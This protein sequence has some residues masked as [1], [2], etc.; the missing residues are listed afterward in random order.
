MQ[1]RNKCPM[2][3]IFFLI[4][5]GCI[6]LSACLSQRATI[7]ATES[8]STPM[9]TPDI[10]VQSPSTETII[11]PGQTSMVTPII[12]VRFTGTPTMTVQPISEYYRQNGHLYCIWEDTPQQA[13]STTQDAAT[14]ETWYIYSNAT[15]GFS[16]R[17]PSNWTLSECTF[18]HPHFLRLQPAQITDEHIMLNIWFRRNTENIGITRTGIGSG[19]VV[20]QGTVQ[21]LN[22]EISR[23]VLI[24]QGKIKAVL[25]NNAQ[26]VSNGPLV[27]TLSIDNFEP[28][29]NAELSQE[30]QADSDDII[31]SF[32]FIS[33]TPTETF[34]P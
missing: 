25:Y 21:F 30:I 15:Y 13:L 32:E 3:Q 17:F 31:K 24:D 29:D 6:I 22:Q 34:M 16:F 19:E 9:M 12:D 4:L 20:Q 7:D 1:K 5:F 11:T 8:V 23:D 14:G 28:D 10:E 26:E 27:F 18:P 33:Q 2:D